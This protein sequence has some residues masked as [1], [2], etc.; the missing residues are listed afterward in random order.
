MTKCKCRQ[1]TESPAKVTS[2]SNTKNYPIFTLPMLGSRNYIVS[3]VVL[4]GHIQRNGKTLSFY[5]LIVEVTRRLIAFDKNA[6]RISFHNINGE[7]G[8]GGLMTAVHDMMNTH[9]A[10]G[11]ALDAISAIQMERMG[12]MLNSEIPTTKDGIVV[13]LYAWQRHIFSLCN[14]YAIY[15]PENIFAVHP[16]LETQFWDFEEGMMGRT[17][18]LS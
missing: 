13:N 16:E 7:L 2:I 3:D 11:P 5:S 1:S 14:A 15:G 12:T 18:P 10:P 6:A 4:A 8:P 9:L 17:L